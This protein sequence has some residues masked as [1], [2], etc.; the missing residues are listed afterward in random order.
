MHCGV[1][2]HAFA[3]LRCAI[4]RAESFAK[5]HPVEAA[6]LPVLYSLSKGCSGVS[7][8]KISPQSELPKLKHLYENEI[9]T[10]RT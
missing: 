8:G 7:D 1:L 4:F 9:N 10:R 6:G 5:Y 3:Y 2:G